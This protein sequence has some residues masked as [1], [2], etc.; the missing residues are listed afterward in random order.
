[1]KLRLAVLGLLL[2]GMAAGASAAL[3]DTGK[4]LSTSF[5]GDLDVLFRDT[6]DNLK[7]VDDSGNVVDTGEEPSSVGG[8]ADFDGDGDL[9]VLFRDTNGNLKYVDDSGNVVDTGANADVVGGVADF[10]G[11]GD[12]DVLFRDTNNNLDYVD[13]SGNVVDTG[14]DTFGVGGVA[15]FDGDGDLDVLF[16]DTN[17]NVKYVDDSGNVVDTGVDAFSVGGVGDFD[18]DGDLDVLFRDTN[19]NLDYVDDSGNVV[20]TGENTFDVGGVAD[21][22]GDGDLDVLFETNINLKYVDDSG[23]VV[24]TGEDTFGVGGVAD[25]DGDT[26]SPPQFSS[27]SVSPDPP[28][29]GQ[30]ADFSYAASDPDGTISSVDLVLKDDGNTIFT[31]TKSTASGTFSPPD[32]LT[33]GDINATFTATDNKG[34]TTTT[35]LTRTLTDTAPSVQ[36]VE[37]TDLKNTKEPA[38]NVSVDS[39]G[40]SDPSEQITVELFKDGAKFDTRTI[41]GKGFVSGSASFDSE[42]SHSFKA[43]A[44]ENAGSNQDSSTFTVDTTP[45]GIQILEPSG[46]TNDTQGIPLKFQAK[47]A[48]TSVDTSTFE[49]AKDGGTRISTN[50]N[51][52]INYG[53]TG[54]HNVTVFAQD[55]A[56]NTG[57]TTKTFTADIKNTLTADT[58]IANTQIDTF[59]ATFSNATDTLRK[60]TT[61]GQLN[62]F[63]TELPKGDVTVTVNSPGFTPSNQT[64]SGV[65][66]SFNQDLNLDLERAGFTFNAFNEQKPTEELDPRTVTITNSTATQQ[67]NKTEVTTEFGNSPAETIPEANSDTVLDQTKTKTGLTVGQLKIEETYDGF[68]TVNLD[69]DVNGQS[70]GKIQDVGTGTTHNLTLDKPKRITSIRIFGTN[71]GDGDGGTG[72]DEDITIEIQ[73]IKALPAET[74]ETTLDFNDIQKSGFPT[75][76]VDVKVESPGFQTRTY[77]AQIDGST[78][79]TLDTFLLPQN[80]GIQPSIEVRDGQQNRLEN[81]QATV[82]REL[83]SKGTKTVAQAETATDGTAAFFLDPDVT[84][85]LLVKKQQFGTFRGSFNPTSYEFE[86]LRIRLKTSSNFT[87]STV[88]DKVDFRLQP[89]QGTVNRTGRTEF[90]FSVSDPENEL[91]QA[92]IKIFVDGRKVNETTVTGSSTGL[93]TALSQNITGL[94]VSQGDNLRVRGFFVKNQEL[95]AVERNYNVLNRLD[96]GPFSLSK[97]TNTFN[98]GS[99]NITQ[100]IIGLLILAAAGTGLNTRVGRTGGG[101]VTLGIL[102]ALTFLGWFTPITFLVSLLVT[103]GVVA[104]G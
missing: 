104:R 77:Q 46:K 86:P 94:N 9:D 20:D 99:T 97:L 54:Q 6:N 87:E 47:D 16:R 34:A 30:T 59:T 88:W 76:D 102:G 25:F 74:G 68:R 103:V 39:T 10:D 40:D 64:L 52:T 44:S 82:L 61:D 69:V 93:S 101:L 33:K 70:V 100:G 80:Q 41:T 78:K 19:G 35:T 65:D 55:Q 32:T 23:N 50:G 29:I 43:V 85:T 24:D 4:G 89:E 13:D 81:A 73:E 58:A 63:T 18:G 42:G 15:D 45:P 22:D 12:L 7:Y 83:G 72:P 66:N 26:N 60:N 84:Y 67:L 96:A 14:E 21:F 28:L 91:T 79:T 17:D 51:T 27:T 37:P 95:E 49:Y 75:G 1:V 62:F 57:Q 2:V 5:Q 11:D 53:T 8:V 3:P 36:V 90:N 38:F 98:Q 48:T 31:G 56:N 71:K 92:G